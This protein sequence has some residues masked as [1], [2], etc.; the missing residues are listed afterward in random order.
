MLTDRGISSRRCLLEKVFPNAALLLSHQARASDRPGPRRSP[1]LSISQERQKK[2]CDAD[3]KS[4]RATPLLV[5][6][7]S[8]LLTTIGRRCLKCFSDAINAL[9]GTVAKVHERSSLRYHRAHQGRCA[10]ASPW[11]A[12]AGTSRALMHIARLNRIE[13]R[14][15]QWSRLVRHKRRSVIWKSRRGRRDRPPKGRAI[16]RETTSRLDFGSRSCRSRQANGLRSH[17]GDCAA[18]PPP[19]LRGV[20][21]MQAWARTPRCQLP[22]SH[23]LWCRTNC[24]E[25]R[26]CSALLGIR[27]AANSRLGKRVIQDDGRWNLFDSNERICKWPRL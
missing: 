5:A 7:A 25:R 24:G 19:W 26:G 27:G 17:F 18:I 8:S 11:W 21:S 23:V 3:E 10:G 20:E 13:Q 4:S 12:C 1:N 15:R 22:P 9:L 2:R 16:L 6:A 14:C